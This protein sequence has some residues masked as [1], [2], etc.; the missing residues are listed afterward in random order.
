MNSIQK[1]V[2]KLFNIKQA[3]TT[4]SGSYAYVNGSLVWMAD[5][6]E[7]YIRNGYGANDIVYSAINLVTEKSSTARVGTL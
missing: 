5:T 1:A 3:L 6:S 7:N 4:G 2:A